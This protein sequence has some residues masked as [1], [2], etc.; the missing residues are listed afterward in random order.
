MSI[1]ELKTL[2]AV[3]ERGSIS[4]AAESMYLSIPAVSAHIQKLEED[5]QV[6]L[7][8]RARRPARLTEAGAALLPRARELV[9][10]YESLHQ[11]VSTPRDLAGS[12]AIGAI[13]TAL[14]GVIPQVLAAL[15]RAHP[16]LHVRLEHGLSPSLAERLRHRELDAAIISEPR[17]LPESLVWT[18]FQEEPVVVIGLMAAKEKTDAELLRKHPY[19]RFNRHFW[20]SKTIEEFLVRKGIMVREVMKLDSLEAIGQMVKHGLGVSI[21]PLSDPS[22]LRFHKIR[23]LPLGKPGLRRRIGL[24]VPRDGG[25][26]LLV[27]SLMELLTRYGQRQAKAF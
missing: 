19:I 23:A 16:R 26:A 25:K 15:R 3:A 24:A 7:L 21:I 5:F 20:V 9:A 13:P 12:L 8:D 6:R 4:A 10:Q 1:R 18:P 27:S 22:F 11:A 14:T 17:A 2:L